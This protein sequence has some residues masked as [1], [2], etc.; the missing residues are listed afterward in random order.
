MLLNSDTPN[1]SNFARTPSDGLAASHAD[2][3]SSRTP[4]SLPRYGPSTA[5]LKWLYGGTE[6]EGEVSLPRR[7][8]L[9][10]AKSLLT[11]ERACA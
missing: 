11:C 2:F 3:L 1:V 8:G 5:I 6:A 7:H 10:G 4:T 9:G